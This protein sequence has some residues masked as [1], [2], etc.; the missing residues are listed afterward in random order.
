[1]I[2]IGLTGFSGSGKDTV[3][4]ALV[5]EHGFVKMSF[6]APLKAMLRRLD[7]IIGHDLYAGCCADCNDADVTE[8]RM[9]DALK[10]GFDDESLKES[11]WAEEV[12]GL[13]E[14][15]GTEVMRSEDP[16]YWIDRAFDSIPADAERIVF[17]DV[18]FQ[19][20]ADAILD[21]R[22]AEITS[23][24]WQIVR[25][26]YEAG[27]HASEQLA[28]LLGEEVQLVNDGELGDISPGVQVALDVT[29][30]GKIPGQME[31]ELDL[32]EG[33]TWK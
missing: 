19:N 33:W 16:D 30:S 18:R 23:S 12:R 31:F 24:L 5:E 2:I 3:A 9:S 28:G 6:A 27:D 14:R 7:P 4:D 13:W 25:P 8:V 15:L 10:F 21:L 22:E 26:G 17:T 29:L 11:L 1:M 32:P 20:E